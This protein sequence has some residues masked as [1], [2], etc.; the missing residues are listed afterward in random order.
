MFLNYINIFYVILFFIVDMGRNGS[1]K[2]CL[3]YACFFK[4]LSSI[5]LI[6]FMLIKKRV[7]GHSVDNVCENF[8]GYALVLSF[9]SFRKLW[10]LMLP[11]NWQGGIFLPH[12]SHLSAS[13]ISPK[14]ALTKCDFK[15]LLTTSSWYVRKNFFMTFITSKGCM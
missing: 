12:G 15:V 10:C 5:M 11:H 9:F 6:N 4:Y 3:V 14:A 13:L 8:S 2:I 1:V 7:Y